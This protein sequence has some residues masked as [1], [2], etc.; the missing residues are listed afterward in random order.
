VTLDNPTPQP[1]RYRVV[2]DG[3][4]HEVVVAAYS[5]ERVPVAIDEDR[6][7]QIVVMAPDATELARTTVRRDC[8]RPRATVALDCSTSSAVFTLANDGATSTLVALVFDG[9]VAVAVPVAGGQQAVVARVP[10]IEDRTI[11]VAARSGDVELVARRLTVDCQPPPDDRGNE[12][13]TTG[14]PTPPTPTPPQVTASSTPP[15]QVL[16]VSARRDSSAPVSLAG[17]TLPTTG[18]DPFALVIAAGWLLILGGFCLV[19][20]ERRTESGF[21]APV[22]RR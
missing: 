2:V 13:P 8:E 3:R 20:S 9:K 5:V 16:G 19:W 11:D 1:I 17:G 4:D 7:L 15:A 12:P 18:S 6:E 14:T 10:V 21:G 22:R